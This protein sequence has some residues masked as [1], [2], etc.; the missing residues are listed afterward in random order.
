RVYALTGEDVEVSDDS[1]GSWS[2][3]AAGYGFEALVPDPQRP[4]T[5]WAAGPDG[6]FR[7]DDGGRTWIPAG[8]GIPQATP[9]TAIAL[10]PVDR[11]VLY[12]GTLRNG[13]FKS[14]DGGLTWEP[15]GTGL[16]G[17]GVRFLVIDPRDRSH[18]YAGTDVAG[19][20]KI[21]QSGD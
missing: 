3:L 19:V 13:V 14:V 10:D 2:L 6:L 12:T 18:L 11:D 8:D 7:S 16:E 20:M 5:L 4:G 9:V 15:L 1:G 21:R 17:F